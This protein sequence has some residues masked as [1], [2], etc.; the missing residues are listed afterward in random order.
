MYIL[1]RELFVRWLPFLLFHKRLAHLLGLAFLLHQWMY[2]PLYRDYTNLAQKQ[3]HQNQRKWYIQSC[4][5]RPQHSAFSNHT[6]FVFF[7]HKEVYFFSL[8]IC[9][10]SLNSFLYYVILILIFLPL[11]FWLNNKNCNKMHTFCYKDL[12]DQ[13][14]HKTP[15]IIGFSQQNQDIFYFILSVTKSIRFRPK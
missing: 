11:F 14:T 2:K 4:R 9:N 10:S 6:W 3:P 13:K 1:L 7:L 8:C 5:R 15:F 12:L